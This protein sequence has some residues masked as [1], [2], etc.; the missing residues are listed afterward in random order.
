[1]LLKSFIYFVGL[2]VFLPYVASAKDCGNYTCA[3]AG[4]WITTRG[5]T[6]VKSAGVCRTVNG[7]V[8]CAASAIRCSKGY[9]A[10]TSS[11]CDGSAP[12]VGYWSRYGTCFTLKCNSCVQDTGA[13]F[14]TST[15][16]EAQNIC[17]CYLQTQTMHYGTNGYYELSAP[18]Y[19]TSVC[20]ENHPAIEYSTS[21]STSSGTSGGGGAS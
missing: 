10:D 17:Q 6:D 5:G 9:Y 21:S 19:Y 4:T 8:Y 1:M 11:G 12:A 20:R 7:T 18:C 15:A 16:G 3:P 14:A 13:G 2:L